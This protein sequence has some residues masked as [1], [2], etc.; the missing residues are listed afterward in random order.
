MEIVFRFNINDLNIDKFYKSKKLIKLFV[1]N[2]INY[3]SNKNYLKF[4]F[5]KI[6]L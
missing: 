5:I 4:L 6:N 2:N 1:I 3:K